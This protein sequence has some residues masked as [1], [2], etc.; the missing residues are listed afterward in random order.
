MTTIVNDYLF[1]AVIWSI[2]GVTLTAFAL[3][4]ALGGQVEQL[5]GLVSASYPREFIISTVLV[6]AT[7][8]VAQLGLPLRALAGPCALAMASRSRGCWC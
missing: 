5:L 2:V 4:V 6:S 7:R 1:A 3:Y 8:E